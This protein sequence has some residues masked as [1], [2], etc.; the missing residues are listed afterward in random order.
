MRRLL[1][2]LA[3]ALVFALF[4]VAAVSAAP[5]AHICENTP[6]HW[7]C[8]TTTTPPTTTQ[9]PTE[10][11]TEPPCVFN[12][13]GVLA[14]WSEADTYI[15]CEW[16]AYSDEEVSFEI[17]SPDDSVTKLQ[18]P[19]LIVNTDSTS[20]DICFHERGNGPQSLP[21]PAD[22]LWTFTPADEGCGDGPY[23]LTIS[24]KPVKTGTMQLVME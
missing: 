9:P 8:S 15:R 5:P 7:S 6:E 13:D 18:L 12:G 10:P 21:F 14:G 23:L 1:I 2:L 22:N 16:D 11:P 4:V 17:Q 20:W 24:V 19:V 3:F